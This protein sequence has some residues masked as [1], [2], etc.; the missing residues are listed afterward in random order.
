MSSNKSFSKQEQSDRALLEN[1]FKNKNNDIK[2]LSSSKNDDTK[3]KEH[4]PI[5]IANM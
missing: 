1:K 2:D 5:E 3:I 4:N